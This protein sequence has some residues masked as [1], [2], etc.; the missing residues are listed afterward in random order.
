MLSLNS[1][2]DAELRRLLVR[3]ERPERLE[4]WRRRVPLEHAAALSAD[5]RRDLPKAP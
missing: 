1:D 4:E 3:L 2:T 5:Q